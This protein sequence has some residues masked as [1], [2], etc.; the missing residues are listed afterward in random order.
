MNRADCVSPVT[1]S[2]IGPG[3]LVFALPIV[4]RYRV[5]TLPVDRQGPPVEGWGHK[6]TFKI[7]DP[8][9]FRSKEIQDRNGAEIKGKVIQWLAKL[10]IYPMGDHQT[11]TLL[12][13]LCYACRQEPSMAV[14]WEALPEADWERCRY[15]QPTIGLG[16]GIPME[17]LGERLKELKGIAIPQEDQQGQLTWTPGTKPPTK[18]MHWLV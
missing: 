13:M 18:S 12:L 10:G 5:S 9:L 11:L 17:E 6:P 2:L 15:P 16:L 8:E 3:F 4:K 7:F 1:L 14:L